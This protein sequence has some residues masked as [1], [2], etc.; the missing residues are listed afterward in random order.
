M[1]TDRHK[2]AIQVIL[3]RY[4][5]PYKAEEDTVYIK[6]S[7]QA[8]ED[9]LFNYTS[10]AEDVPLDEVMGYLQW[11]ESPNPENRGR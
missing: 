2:L 1:L 4:G 9:L 6:G 5:E 3:W 7:L 8:D 10:K 11:P